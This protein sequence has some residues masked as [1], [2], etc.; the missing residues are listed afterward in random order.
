MVLSRVV[1][2][3]SLLS[4]ELVFGMLPI[5]I[6]GYRFIKPASPDNE[7]SSNKVFYVKGLDYQPGGSSG[8]NPESDE[9]VLTDEGKCA[10]DVAVFQ[11]IGI[12]T[13]RIYS[14]N[15]DL[16][17]DK[18]MTILNNAGIYVI[19]DV[20]SGNYG[21]HLNRADPEGSYN[22]QYLS[23]VFKFID[24]FKNYPNVLGFFAGNEVI[25]DQ[26]NYE[27]TTPPYIR[28]LQR[29]M[30]QYIAKHAD[31]HI[32]V[33]YSAA[34]IE[35]LRIPTL[36]YLQ[37]NSLSGSTVDSKLEESKSDFFGLNTYEWCSG[38]TWTQSGYDKLNSSLSDPGIPLIFSEYGCNTRTPRTFEEVS[39]GL[40]A[41][42]TD[43]SGGLVYEY[44]NEQNNYGLVDVDTSGNIKFR[45][46]LVNL[47]NQ[48]NKL[49]LPDI[50]EEDV[51]NITAVECS[52]SK[53]SSVSSN[54]GTKNFTIPAQPS[55][56][57]SLI[58]EGAKGSN[59][60][61]ILS[62]YTAP[63]SA[64]YTIL[65]TD[66]NKVDATITYDSANFQNKLGTSVSITINTSSASSTKST[67]S[68]AASSTGS[69]KNE[70]VVG[71]PVYGGFTAGLIA[72]IASLL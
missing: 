70:A 13:I 28:A 9:D 68:S 37:C 10:R 1:L 67:S 2:L 24:A 52:A 46:D 16:N 64:S 5:H 40:Y 54:F 42:L 71:V 48:Y 49:S 55:E 72:L 39:D 47:K 25:N 36:E 18:C 45:D 35:E 4:T 57:E 27:T 69:S 65:D 33:G 53:I 20:N 41:G 50:T 14:L 63:T 30:K 51:Q 61:S 32:P 26:E 17:H 12:N 58:N 3:L 8:Y 29:D 23:R 59:T 6:K 22:A 19:L 43:L 38:S 7:P 11:Q 34:D 31:R 56:I 66:G 44:S 60:G 62:D 21:E 15:P